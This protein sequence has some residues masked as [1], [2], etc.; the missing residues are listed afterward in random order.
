MNGSDQDTLTAQLFRYAQDLDQLIQQHKRLQQQHQMIL[1]SLGQEVPGEDLLP[2]QLQQTAALHWVTDFQGRVIQAGRTNPAPWAQH[3][4]GQRDQDLV[5]LLARGQR[6]AVRQ[7]LARFDETNAGAVQLPLKAEPLPGLPDTLAFD[8]LVMPNRRSGRP[9]LEWFLYPGDSPQ[10]NAAQTPLAMVRSVLPEHCIMAVAP[11]GCI[12]AVSQGYC[13]ATGHS[14][15]AL[16]GN[17]P[18]MLSSGRHDAHFYSEFWSELR[19]NGGWNGTLFNRRR[20]G[21]IYLIWQVVR[22]VSDQYGQLLYYLSAVVDISYAEPS[23]KRL[24]VIAYTD[25]LTGLPN[26]RM[27]S[28]RLTQALDEARQTGQ[29]LALLFIDLD[30]FKPINDDLGH[31]MG[32]LVLHEVARRMRGALLPGDL[33]A[34]VG[35]DEFV[36]LLYSHKRVEMAEAIGAQL[37]QVLKPTL[38]I[39]NCEISIGASMGCARYPQDGE[40]METLLQRADAAMYGSKR[41]GIPFCYYDAG[42]NEVVLPNLEFD[43]WQALERGEIS[44]V[45]QPQVCSD[46]GRSLRGV[47]ALMR[48][49]HPVLGDVEPSHFITLAEHSGAI[50][51][52]GQWV[53]ATACAQLREWREQGLPTFTLSVNISLRQLRHPGFLSTVRQALAA[54]Q[55]EACDLE[56]EFSETQAMLFMQSDT[57]HVQALR[58]LGVRIAIDDYGISFSSLSRLNFLTISSFKLNPQCVQDL[59]TSSDARAISNCMINIS[60]AMG[61]EV[62]AQGVETAEQASVLEQQ[63]CRVLQGFYTGAPVH[64][65]ALRELLGAA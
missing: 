36:V 37:Q 16:L 4:S 9:T 35:G 42:I 53:L 31:A 58:Q 46:E 17:K 60:K 3:P 33:L 8:A 20:D 62:I 25:P 2:K 51:P 50:V 40:D 56:M 28:D 23:V 19:H 30:R 65:A 12:W 22:K 5:Q 10:D 29:K 41:F 14:E 15:E 34:R 54:N 26:R 6:D 52:L 64:A 1:Q 59:T 55:L 27:L 38:R 21:H 61:I 43:L 18:S 11:D 49:T 63:G 39:Q 7:M 47:E 48:W 44:L 24:Q 45:Y 13:D 57:A 32:D